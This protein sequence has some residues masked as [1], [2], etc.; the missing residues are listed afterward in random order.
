VNYDE[1]KGKRVNYEGE[2]DEWNWERESDW[3]WKGE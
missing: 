1:W 3:K 2:C